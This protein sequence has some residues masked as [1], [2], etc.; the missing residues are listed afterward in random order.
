[1]LVIEGASFFQCNNIICFKIA[2]HEEELHPT[3]GELQ[4]GMLFQEA[5]HNIGL[6]MLI[7]QFD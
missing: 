2:T 7:S 5:V 3:W 4:F 1:M 6:H